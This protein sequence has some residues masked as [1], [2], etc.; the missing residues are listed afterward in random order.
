MMLPR[1]DHASYDDTNRNRL[2]ADVYW[3]ESWPNSDVILSLTWGN[4]NSDPVWCV[5]F[6][7]TAPPLLVVAAAVRLE[8][9]LDRRRR[10]LTGWHPERRREWDRNTG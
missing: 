10:R 7:W 5:D 8:R 6:V 2:L 3:P 1:L 4:G 9:R